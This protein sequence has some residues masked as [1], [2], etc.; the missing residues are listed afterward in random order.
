MLLSLKIE[1]LLLG[2]RSGSHS[3]VWLVGRRWFCKHTNTGKY[4]C[5][6]R[7]G[8]VYTKPKD[9]LVASFVRKEEETLSVLLLGLDWQ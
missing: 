2:S 4:Y 8:E 6:K 7:G 9:F 1:P 5:Y 3:A